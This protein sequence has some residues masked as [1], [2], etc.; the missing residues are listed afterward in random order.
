MPHTFIN[1]LLGQWDGVQH[2][3]YQGSKS[4]LVYFAGYVCTMYCP[5]L[6]YKSRAGQGTLVS[7][8]RI[9]FHGTKAAALVTKLY[10]NQGKES[11]SLLLTVGQISCNVQSLG[12]TSRVH[13]SGSRVGSM[14]R[15]QESGSGVG[16]RS[17]VQESGPG[18]RS[19]SQV[20]ESG[21]VVRSRSQVQESSLA[22][23]WQAREMQNMGNT[24]VCYLQ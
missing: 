16:S 1:C 13:K 6:V 19:R 2:K 5:A 22:H 21:P 10:F 8:S 11:I 24:I 12:S 23:T 15:V 7:I 14:S 18:V 17:Q 20:Q 3:W 9:I 4:C